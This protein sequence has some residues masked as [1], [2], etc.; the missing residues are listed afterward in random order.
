M[1]IS[2]KKCTFRLPLISPVRCRSKEDEKRQRGSSS[3]E[4]LFSFLLLL[5]MCFGYIDIVFQGYNGLIIDY[6]SYMGARGYI[7][8]EP[9]GTKWKEGAETIG[10][11][12]M[13]HKVIEAFERDDD[14]ILSVTNGEMLRSGIIY[15][16]RR[17]GTIEV[18]TSLGEQ[19]PG[20]EGDN[21]SGGSSQ[22]FWP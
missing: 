16:N 3:V 8:D 14:I 11:G 17:E 15:G 19:E 20:L 12:T 10:L 9:N 6:G 13:M 18:S 4:F 5:W 1:R 7:V 22:P 2:F 21:A